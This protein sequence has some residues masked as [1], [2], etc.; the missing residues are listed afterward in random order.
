M[1][2]NVPTVIR[3]GTLEDRFKILKAD[4]KSGFLYLKAELP[5]QTKINAC[6]Q[7]YAN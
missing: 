5:E 1:D 6:K 2:R 3:S 7:D 4:M